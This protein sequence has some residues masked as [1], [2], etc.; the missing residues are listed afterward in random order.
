MNKPLIPFLILFILALLTILN[1]PL[2]RGQVLGVSTETYTADS[3]KDETRIITTTAFDQKEE[4]ETVT[5]PYETTYEDDEET[6]YGMEKVLQEGVNGTKKLKY[7][8]TF[9]QDEEIDRQLISTETEDPVGEKLQLKIVWHDL[10]G[11]D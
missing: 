11:G 4:F 9:W 5:I 1:L 10:P 7:L 8:I 3:L 2:F 6:E